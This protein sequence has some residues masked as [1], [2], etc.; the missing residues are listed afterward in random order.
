MDF[1]RPSAVESRKVE[2]PAETLQIEALRGGFVEMARRSSL[3][4][5][6]KCDRRFPVRLRKVPAG[7]CAEPPVRDASA[8]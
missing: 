6:L 8:T 1:L 4:E 7:M 3:A 2:H 5:A